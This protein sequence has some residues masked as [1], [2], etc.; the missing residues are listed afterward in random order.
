MRG[1]RLRLLG[2]R[3]ETGLYHL[4]RLRAIQDRMSCLEIVPALSEH[5]PPGWA[6]ETGLITD[7]IG[8]R[9]PRLD[10]YDAYLCGPPAMIDAATALLTARGVRPRNVYFDAF[11]PTG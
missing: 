1:V 5:I 10:G 8:R 11:V 7:V 4:D 6:G 3:T 2:A 9:F